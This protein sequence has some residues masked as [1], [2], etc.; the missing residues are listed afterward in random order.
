M[1]RSNNPD[2]LMRSAF[3]LIFPSRGPLEHVDTVNCM[4][5]DP[6]SI[7]EV[8]LWTFIVFFNKVGLPTAECWQQVYKAEGEYEFSQ[9]TDLTL[10]CSLR[11][12]INFCCTRACHSKWFFEGN[13]ASPTAITQDHIICQHSGPC[14]NGYS[15]VVGEH[16]QVKVSFQLIVKFIN[17]EADAFAQPWNLILPFGADHDKM[18][19]QWPPMQEWFE[20]CPWHHKYQGISGQKRAAAVAER[21]MRE[22]R[23][24]YGRFARIR[25]VGLVAVNFERNRMEEKMETKMIA[26]KRKHQE[27]MAMMDNTMADLVKRLCPDKQD[28]GTSTIDVVDLEEDS[29][30][31]DTWRQFTENSFTYVGPST[32][33]QR[34]WYLD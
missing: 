8:R 18:A 24:F 17:M 2:L 10:R 7:G 4:N 12:K 26:L 9:L 29:P 23:N 16:V 27:E 14:S 20:L 21:V 5:S 15:G 25:Q 28:A 22:L 31:E 3:R 33:V 1:T 34:I 11:C 19:E 13:D 6:K 32:E 30:D